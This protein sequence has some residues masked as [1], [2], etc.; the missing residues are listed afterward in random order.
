MNWLMLQKL[1]HREQRIALEELL[2]AVR[3]ESERIE[4]LEQAIRDAVPEW[5]Q[6]SLQDSGGP[7]GAG[8]AA[9]ARADHDGIVGRIAAG[10]DAVVGEPRVG[11]DP[12][13]ERHA[14]LVRVGEAEDAL[15]QRLGFFAREDAHRCRPVLMTATLRKRAGTQPWLTALDWL[16]CPLPSL[17]APPRR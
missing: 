8:P 6:R 13:G 12:R 15:G 10:G 4:R 5:S 3:Q 11:L 9:K 7:F 17:N 2:G 16:G 14:A 1:E